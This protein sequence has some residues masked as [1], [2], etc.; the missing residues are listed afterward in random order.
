MSRVTFLNGE[1]IS[2]RVSVSKCVT[3]DRT[4]GVR[5]S[6]VTRSIMS[7]YLAVLEPKLWHGGFVRLLLLVSQLD[8]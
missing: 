5:P 2:P 1:G 3:F 8:F 7:S 6:S 4:G